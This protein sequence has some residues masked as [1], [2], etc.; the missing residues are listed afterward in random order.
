[1]ARGQEGGIHA[2]QR[3]EFGQEF[4][5]A[6]HAMHSVAEARRRGEVFAVT[7]RL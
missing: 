4:F 7:L 2:G 3:D 6:L 5:R 1:M